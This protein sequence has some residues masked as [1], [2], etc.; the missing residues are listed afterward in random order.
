MEQRQRKD[1]RII[2][3]AGAAILPLTLGGGAG[4]EVLSQDDTAVCL[5]SQ[6][7]LCGSRLPCILL[8]FQLPGETYSAPA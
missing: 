1:G 2:S 7:G 5:W 6:V 8:Q 3:V 4:T